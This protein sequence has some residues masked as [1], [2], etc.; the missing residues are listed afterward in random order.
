MDNLPMHYRLDDHWEEDG[1]VVVVL[2]KFHAIRE[3]PHGYWVLPAYYWHHREAFPAW[4]EK[5]NRW[6]PKVGARFCHA[7]LENAKLHFEIRKH[8]ELRHIQ[9]RLAK[10]KQVHD[11]WADLSVE[12]LE[13]YGEVNLGKP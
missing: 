5:H 11:Q 8:H 7:S 4:K 12:T 2:R 6:V 10:C 13:K 1:S 9:A 3:T